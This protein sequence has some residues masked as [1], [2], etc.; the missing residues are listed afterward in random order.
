MTLRTEG[1]NESSSE[2][3]PGTIL[4]FGSLNLT[5]K[6]HLKKH[7]FEKY[8]IKWEELETLDNLRFIRKHKHF[9]KRIEL[10]SDN[11]T[12]DMLIH[13]NKSSKRIMKIGYVA[14]QKIKYKG[15]EAHFQ[16]MI[17]FATSQ[18]GLYI[19]SCDVCTCPVY[20]QLLLDYD[21]EQ[22][23]FVLSDNCYKKENDNKI[24]NEFGEKVDNNKTTK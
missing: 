5:L 2:I 3:G 22:K 21:N 13:I 18:N 17:R 14:C 9:W 6:L 16:E 24:E 12:L 11:N 15:K 4:S 23:V 7:D 20:I 10:S 1:V 8:E 19:T